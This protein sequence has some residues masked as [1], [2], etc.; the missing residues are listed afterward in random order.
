M[1][2]EKTSDSSRT[3]H[4]PR[5]AAPFC[6][7]QPSSV[8]A[9]TH[10][11]SQVL[12]VRRDPEGWIAQSHL[13][14]LYRAAD[15]LPG[16]H[17]LRT[18]APPRSGLRLI[19][20]LAVT[21]RALATVH[22]ASS[23]RRPSPPTVFSPRA[24]VTR[25]SRQC[26]WAPRH[27]LTTAIPPTS[28]L[29]PLARARSQRRTSASPRCSS[30]VCPSVTLCATRSIHRPRNSGY[31]GLRVRNGA[32]LTQ[33]PL[34]ACRPSTVRPTHS[35]RQYEISERRAMLSAF[36]G[37]AFPSSKCRVCSG[38]GQCKGRMDRNVRWYRPSPARSPHPQPQG[39]RCA[40]CPCCRRIAMRIV[41]KTS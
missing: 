14:F 12:T 3:P 41:G 4:P 40:R 38:A 21:K 9:V 13:C 1:D 31:I 22:K 26:F 8:D 36:L 17:V 5:S 23:P 10:R 35:G 29:P 15:T 33:T 25:G 2:R 18:S 27:T 19:L 11:V 30:R 16:C 24:R 6:V 34:L 20:L 28:T 37:I 7:G 39:A 32:P